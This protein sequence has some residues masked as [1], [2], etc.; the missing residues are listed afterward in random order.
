[1]VIP[2]PLCGKT[3]LPNRL[4]NGKNRCLFIHRCCSASHAPYKLIPVGKRCVLCESLELPV[5]V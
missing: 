2:S 3:G 4:G 5:E 1:M